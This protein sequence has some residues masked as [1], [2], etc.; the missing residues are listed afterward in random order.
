[1]D[2]NRQIPQ[3]SSKWIK[4]SEPE[5][6]IARHSVERSKVEYFCTCQWLCSVCASGLA[7]TPRE[8]G[9]HLQ[10]WRDTHTDERELLSQFLFRSI[11]YTK[12]SR[13]WVAESNVWGWRGLLLVEAMLWSVSSVECGVLHPEH[14]IMWVQLVRW[15]RLFHMN[16]DVLTWFCPLGI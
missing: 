3:C 1:M 16:S 5:I 14:I 15:K 7:G 2:Y 11:L 8:T 4:G 10:P 13:I 6:I 12:F 9:L